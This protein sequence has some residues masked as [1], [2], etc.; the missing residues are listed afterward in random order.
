MLIPARTQRVKG[1]DYLIADH[2]GAMRY[3]GGNDRRLPCP[4]RDGDASDS[5]LNLAG[6]HKC[7][8]FLGMVMLRKDRA[9]LVDIPH[10]RLTLAVDSLAGDARVNLSRGNCGPGNFLHLEGQPATEQA[11]G[12][13]EEDDARDAHAEDEPQQQ[14]KHEQYAEGSAI[15]HL[16]LREN[17]RRRGVA[18]E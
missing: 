6:D 18:T 10:H 8:L 2:T 9:W 3:P 7:D 16:R 14:P 4:E 1:L 15:E 5:E 13:Q 12:E 17:G 11:E